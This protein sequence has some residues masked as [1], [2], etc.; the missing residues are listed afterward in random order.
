MKLGKLPATHDHRDLCF[1]HYRSRTKLPPRPPEFG[2]ESCVADWGVLGNDLYGDCVLAGAAHEAMLVN[3]THAKEVQFSVEGVLSDYSATAGFDP[4][5][6]EETDNGTDVRKALSY[7]RKTG[8]IDASGHR[9]KILAYLAIEPGHMEQLLEALF[10]FGT[11]G[12]GLEMPSNAERL[13]DARKTWVVQHGT[14]TEGGHYVPLVAYR[15][16]ELRCVTWGALQN[17]SLRFF[18]KYCDEA[19]VTLTDE[20]LDY[21]GK[22]PEGFD[23][24]ALRADLAKVAT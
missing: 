4:E 24:R 12:V 19:W 13:F 21:Q 1:G 6:P 23:L 10:L 18:E 8:V 22:S 11:V 20:L 9:H 16:H 7:R 2:H 5:R 17:M 15:F 3:G 14:R